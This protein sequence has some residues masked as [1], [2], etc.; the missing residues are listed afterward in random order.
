MIEIPL[1]RGKIALVDDAD[2][3][4]VS[5]YKWRAVKNEAFGQTYWYA[6]AHL[7]MVD[8]RR[9]DVKMHRLIMGAPDGVQVDHR[10]FDGLNN[11]RYNIR[12]ASAVQNGSHRRKSVAILAVRCSSPFKG[13]TFVADQRVK[14]RPWKAMIGYKNERRLVG[15]FATDKEAAAAYDAAARTLHGEFAKLNFPDS[16]GA[17]KED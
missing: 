16:A 15:Y 13:V 6:Q 9:K 1:T 4:T 3:E 2:F 12:I 17:Q 11:Q 10:D 5:R 14:S 8:G 7:P